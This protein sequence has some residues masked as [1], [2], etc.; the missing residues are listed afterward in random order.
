MNAPHRCQRAASSVPTRHDTMLQAIVPD[1]MRRRALNRRGVAHGGEA[2][3][4]A[5][6]LP[7]T[8]GGPGGTATPSLSAVPARPTKVGC[9]AEGTDGRHRTAR[10]DVMPDVFPGLSGSGD[11]LTA[12][13]RSSVGARRRCSDGLGGDAAQA[14]PRRAGRDSDL[15]ELR[16][17]SGGCARSR[18]RSGGPGV[19][20]ASCRRGRA[21]GCGAAQPRGPGRSA[22]FP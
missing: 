11:G 14:R 19:R 13:N 4:P 22:W 12:R 18:R 9:D 5:R 6:R 20:K 3:G 2:Q 21:R 7:P 8:S 10:L 16:R 1:P 17:P 15:L